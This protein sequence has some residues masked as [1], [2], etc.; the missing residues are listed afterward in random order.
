LGGDDRMLTI[1]NESGDTIRQTSLRDLPAGITFSD[2][3][4]DIRSQL[5]EGTISLIMNR[6]TLYLFNIDDPDK[7][8]E[9]AFQ[10]KYGDVTNYKWYGDG[11]LMIGFSHGFLIVIST[12]EK[13]IGTVI[14]E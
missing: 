2:R 13:E 8:I 4:Q 6:K 3:K 5:Q 1:S 7:P 12:H 10:P 9:L 11:Y 14:I